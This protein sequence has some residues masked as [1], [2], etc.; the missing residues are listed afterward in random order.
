MHHIV[1]KRQ[2]GFQ[3]YPTDDIYDISFEMIAVLRWLFLLGLTSICAIASNNQPTRSFY[4]DSNT[5]PGVELTHDNSNVIKRTGFIFQ[6]S[7]NWI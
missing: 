4:R 5:T 7:A 3:S 6:T 2:T 1:S